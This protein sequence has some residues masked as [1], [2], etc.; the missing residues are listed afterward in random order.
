IPIC[1]GLILVCAVTIPALTTNMFRSEKLD[2]D[3]SDISD[4]GEWYGL[5]SRSNLEV[6]PES[7]PKSAENVE[8]RFYNDDSIDPSSLV[9]LKCTYDSSDYSAEI[10][11]LESIDGVH[12]DDENYS[13]TAYVTLL[14]KFESEYALVTDDNTIVYVCFAEG[15]IPE[16][17]K[18]EYLRNS[19]AEDSEWFSIY[20]FSDY[21]DYKYWPETWKQRR[22]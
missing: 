15:V 17:P 13:G 4:Y 9:F 3:T 11:R 5:L 7:I 20:D 16:L 2:R 10:A 21:D 14:H 1:V 8:Y 22:N 18:S 19:T 6:F 12:K